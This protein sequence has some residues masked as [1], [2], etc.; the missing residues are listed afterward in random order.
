MVNSFGH[1][2]LVNRT[3]RN[4]LNFISEALKPDSGIVF[5]TPIAHLIPQIPTA[6]IIGYSSLL[7]CGGYSTKFWWHLTIL[8]NITT[9]TLLHL[10]DNSD[11][12]FISINCLE[13]VTIILNYCTSLIVF[14]TQKISCLSFL[15]TRLNP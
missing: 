12:S 2:Y 10:K 14:A 13:F 5:E 6:S 1:K 8:P 9:R 7:S 11:K 4:V 15:S 3:M